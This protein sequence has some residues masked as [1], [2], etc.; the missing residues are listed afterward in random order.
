[1]SSHVELAVTG[2]TSTPDGYGLA[3]ETVTLQCN[4]PSTQLPI[5]ITWSFTSA[6]SDNTVMLPDKD[7]T[8]ES[9]M[10]Y[11]RLVIS[12]FQVEH[13]GNYSCSISVLGGEDVLLGGITSVEKTVRLAGNCGTLV[14]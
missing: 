5:D 2:I 6:N 7:A 9:T 3:G 4:F 13:S 14:M 8:I 10:G 12:T 1:M 11:G